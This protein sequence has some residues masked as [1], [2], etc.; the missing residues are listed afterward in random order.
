MN[1]RWHFYSL[2]TGLFSSRTYAGPE[3]GVADQLAAASEGQPM[4]ALFG[5]YSPTTHRVDLSSGLVVPW[6]SP[7]PADTMY[8]TWSWHAGQC[9]YL[10]ELTPAGL[11]HDLRAERDR[12]LAQCDWVVVRA[13]ESGQAVPSA[14]ATY[15]QAL[16]DVSLQPDFPLHIQWPANPAG[17]PE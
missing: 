17:A 16:R 13:T 15:R 9:R 14:W 6:Q 11:A 2:E 12:R 7:K 8:T 10:P 4:A 1:E 5:D 3:S